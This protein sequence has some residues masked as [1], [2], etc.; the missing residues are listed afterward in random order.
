MLLVVLGRGEADRLRAGGVD[1]QDREDRARR[2]LRQGQL[3]VARSRRAASTL[4]GRTDLYAVGIIL[5]ELLTGRQ[6]FPQSEHNADRARAR[7]R[8]SSRRR[9]TRS[10]VPPALD[11]IVHEGAGQGQDAALRRL[12]GVPRGA[13]RLPG[14]D[15]A[16]HRRRR[17][18][19][20]FLRQL[21][22]GEIEDER[23][24]RQQ[25]LE[26]A[27]EVGGRALASPR[28]SSRR[29]VAK[30]NVSQPATASLQPSDKHDDKKP[31][32][33]GP[34]TSD[35]GIVGTLHRRQVPRPRLIGE[36]GM[37]RVYEAEHVEIG[38]RV[39]VK[40]LHPAYTRQA[41]VVERFRSRGARGV[42]HRPPAHR[43]RH[44]LRHDRRRRG[45]LRHGVPRG[46][47]LGAA[48]RAR[49]AARRRRARSRSP[50]RF[51]RRWRRRT[52]R[53]SSTAISSPRTSS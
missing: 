37:G 11:A 52:R 29:Q 12:R 14:A 42:A 1:A 32:H 24:Q 26:Q 38:R 40:V 8:R 51:A 7:S 44:R 21:F 19:S 53:A 20:S 5:W 34:P 50:R 31:A 25:M 3:H 2:R 43:R 46:R 27:L 47:E 17:A 15:R 10:R 13:G 16:D 45:L 9:R 36:G 23:T 33:D 30:Q 41:E 4:D 22:D 39:A 28:R 6:L 35:D 49:R 18:S 48:H